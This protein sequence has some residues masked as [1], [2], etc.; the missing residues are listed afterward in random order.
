MTTPTEPLAATSVLV[1]EDDYYLAKDLQQALEAVGSTVIGP[2]AN[3]ADAARATGER[4][5]GCA[6]V[7]VNLG[8]G[9][10]F[11]IP[12]RLRGADVPFLFVTGYDAG[13]IPPEFADVP[14]LE[15]PVGRRRIVEAA[16]SLLRLD[17]RPG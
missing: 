3:E 4:T 10:S 8:A 17:E 16:N 14:R 9:P 7:D 6:F 12:R 13:T 1:L 5:P 11:E 15:K 2:F